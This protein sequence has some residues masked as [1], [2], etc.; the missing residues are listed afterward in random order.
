MAVTI[1]A[2]LITDATAP[3]DPAS[4]KSRIV[5]IGG[6]Y[7]DDPDFHITPLGRMP[8]TLVLINAV[9]AFLTNDHI[10]DVPILLRIGVEA[11][12]ILVM[13]A[14]PLRLPPGAV[15]WTGSAFVCIMAVTAGNVFLD[16]G[17]WIDPVIPL[18]GILGDE[19]REQITH[20]LKERKKVAI[21]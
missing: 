8:G 14:L 1:P 13:S 11:I 6:S 15:I 12:V 4:I 18:L 9:N 2:R 3:Y 20:A 10:R 21:S 16:R 5:V 17:Y 19:V 7:A